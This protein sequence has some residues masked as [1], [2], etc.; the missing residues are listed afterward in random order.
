MVSREVGLRR[1][2]SFAF[3]WDLPVALVGT[4]YRRC[5]KFRAGKRHFDLRRRCD[6]LSCVDLLAAMGLIA[7]TFPSVSKGQLAGLET[8]LGHCLM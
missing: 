5:T 3:V 7:V 2:M 4:K 8:R 1:H 6:S